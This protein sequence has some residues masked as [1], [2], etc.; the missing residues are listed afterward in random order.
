MRNSLKKLT[1]TLATASAWLA[2]TASPAQ[3]QYRE[4]TLTS[5][6]AAWAITSIPERVGHGNRA[7]RVILRCQ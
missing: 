3:A 6:D 1:L 2:F 5:I 4:T 7:G